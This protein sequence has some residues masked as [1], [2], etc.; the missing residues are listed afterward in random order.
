M[1]QPYHGTE[2]HYKQH[3]QSQEVATGTLRSILKS[4]GINL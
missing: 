1:V 3:H 4:A 2:I